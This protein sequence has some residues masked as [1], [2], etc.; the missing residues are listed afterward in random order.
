MFCNGKKKDGQPCRK[1]VNVDGGFCNLHKSQLHKAAMDWH[2]KYMEDKIG[3][4]EWE[5]LK[6]LVDKHS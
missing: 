3:K 5:R 1:K 4:K 2:D 6:K